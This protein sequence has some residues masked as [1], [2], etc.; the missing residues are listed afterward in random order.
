MAERHFQGGEALDR[1]ITEAEATLLDSLGAGEL[2]LMEDLRKEAFAEA[3][4][5]YPDQ[6]AED[7]HQDAFRHAYWNALLVAY[8]GEDFARAF[9]TA[10]EGLPGNFAAREAMDLYNNEV[11]RSIGVDLASF[12]TPPDFRLADAVDQALQDGRLVVID[13]DGESLRWSNQVAP[14]QTGTTSSTILPG[15]LNTP[16]PPS[17]S[18]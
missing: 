16:A 4:A 11:G 5:R 10:H 3:E 15:V 13:L 9:T 2:Q 17:G 18:T 7:G 12:S 1:T 6:G 14:G 8:F